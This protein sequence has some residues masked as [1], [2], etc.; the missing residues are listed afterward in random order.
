MPTIVLA[1]AGGPAA[2]AAMPRL[3]RAYGAAV[4]EMSAAAQPDHAIV[5]AYGPPTHASEPRSIAS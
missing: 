2:L 1:C 3:C 4:A 5:G